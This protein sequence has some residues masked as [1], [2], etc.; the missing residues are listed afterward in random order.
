MIPPNQLAHVIHIE[1]E[2]D[3]ED[4]LRL[5]AAKAAKAATRPPMAPGRFAHLVAAFVERRRLGRQAP[6]VG[7]CDERTVTTSAACC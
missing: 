1:R 3:L 2:R 7:V 6:A 5:R 4:W